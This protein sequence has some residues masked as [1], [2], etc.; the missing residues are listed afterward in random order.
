[1]VS[2]LSQDT[3]FKISKS[4]PD[5]RTQM[6]NTLAFGLLMRVLTIWLKISKE[7]GLAQ[8]KKR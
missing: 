1:M 2:L 7:H 3:S 6:P 5:K 4:L 8:R